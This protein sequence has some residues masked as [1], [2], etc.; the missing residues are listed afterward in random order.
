VRGSV[1]NFKK[2]TEMFD[3]AVGELKTAGAT[4][5]DIVIPNL[6]SALAKRS[7]NPEDDSSAVYFARNPN[8]PYRTQKDMES[9]PEYGNIFSRRRAGARTAAAGANPTGGTPQSRYYDYVVARDR[10]MIDIIQVM[11]ENKLDAIVHKSMH[12]TPTL[13]KDGINPLFV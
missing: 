12:H 13:I 7:S 1:S 8:S 3:F 6:N 4:T 11:A 9:Y 5:V 10:L 2:V